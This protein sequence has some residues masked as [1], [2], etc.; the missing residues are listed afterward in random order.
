MSLFIGFRIL[1][2]HYTTMDRSWGWLPGIPDNR[3]P[4]GPISQTIAAD[5][6]GFVLA[7]FCRTSAESAQ[8][9]FQDAVA[10]AEEAQT[11]VYARVALNKFLVQKMYRCCNR[12]HSGDVLRKEVVPLWGATG[13][14]EEYMCL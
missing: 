10:A 9:R 5:E 11:E 4:S 14:V 1:G 13:F 8:E 2:M 7:S 6:T 12:R 3:N